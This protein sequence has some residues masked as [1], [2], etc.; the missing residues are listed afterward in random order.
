M[1]NLDLGSR[2]NAIYTHV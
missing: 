2:L 1:Y